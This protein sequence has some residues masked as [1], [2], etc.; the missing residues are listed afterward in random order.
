MAQLLSMKPGTKRLLVWMLLRAHAWL[1]TRSP[2]WVVLEA[3]NEWCSS[4]SS[5]FLSIFLPPSKSNRQILKCINGEPLWKLLLCG[6]A[7]PRRWCCRWGHS[8]ACPALRSALWQRSLTHLGSPG[9][10]Q[11]GWQNLSVP[12]GQPLGHW[13]LHGQEESRALWLNTTTDSSPGL[14]GGPETVSEASP[15]QDPPAE[16]AVGTEPST[17]HPVEEATGARA[18]GVMPLIRQA[19]P[20]GLDCGHPGK[21]QK[22]T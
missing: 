16:A 22:G 17:S 11:T 20:R 5:M 12:E 21:V 10:P 8:V 1:H 3:A 18:T 4:L 13:T 19:Q 14:S 6:A 7:R 2:V 9:A 15:A